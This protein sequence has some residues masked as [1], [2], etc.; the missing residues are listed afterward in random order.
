MRHYGLTSKYG[1][2][3]AIMI[4]AYASCMPELC[5]AVVINVPPMT[6][7]GFIDSNTELNLFGAG[8]IPDD[9][10]A[11]SFAGTSTNINVNINGGVTGENFSANAGTTVTVT[12]GTVGDFFDAFDDSVI[13]INGGTIGSFFDA[14]GGS[15]INI[16]GGS[17]GQGFDALN[18]SVVNFRGGTFLGEFDA[19]GGSTVN[20]LGSS[21]VLNGS[22]LSLLP[23]VTFPVSS[24]N[25]M[26]SGILLDGSSFQFDLNSTNAAFQDYFSDSAALTVTIPAAADFDL[27]LDVDNE[28][29]VIWITDYGST[30]TVIA[31][32]DGDGDSDGADFLIWQREFTGGPLNYAEIATVPEPG[33]AVPI[34]L[35][36]G[37]GM[38]RTTRNFLFRRALNRV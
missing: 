26:L 23:G 15:Q 30:G 19:A 17:I 12:G 20:L 13:N 5:R 1:K 38:S 25:I 8:T 11:G 28:D 16:T 22:L 21:F 36:V 32:A 35:C 4:C 14:N 34:C 7:P 29:L 2:L 33:A 37:W 18:G 3:S 24:R 9:F 31:D 27:D 6:A 10:V